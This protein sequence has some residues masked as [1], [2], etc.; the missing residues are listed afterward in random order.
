MSLF[1]TP[2]VPPSVSPPVIVAPCV[3]CK[4]FDPAS[5][6]FVS[7]AAAVRLNSALIV[8]VSA[9]AV[10]APAKLCAPLIVSAVPALVQADRGD[11]AR[12]D[13]GPRRRPSPA[14]TRP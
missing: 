2:V 3:S 7:V 5:L 9:E 12:S 6:T 4:A 14:S 11:H 8:I 13:G 10:S 1:V